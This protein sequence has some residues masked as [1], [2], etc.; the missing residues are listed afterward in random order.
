MQAFTTLTATAVPLD[1]ANVDTDQL[2][3]ARF[4]RKPRSAGYGNF[5]L[6]DVRFDADGRPRGDC[7]L[8]DPAYAGAKILIAGAN[9]G[10][11]S[12]REAAVY[13]LVDF[14]IR[15]VIASGF[16]DIFRANAVKNGLLPADVAESDA[17]RLIDAVTANPHGRV[18]AN[19]HDR[20][21]KLAEEGQAITFTIPDHQR[22]QLLEGRDDIDLTLQYGGAIAAFVARD[23]AARPWAAPRQ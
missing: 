18:T 2:I 17:R 3:P 21:I 16:G 15:C 11:G 5:L 13:A 23:R 1:R 20:T 4:M 10:G 22:E 8:D 12:S 19:L 9:F 7:A 6:H 14:G